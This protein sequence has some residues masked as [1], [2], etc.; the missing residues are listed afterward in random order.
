VRDQGH[1]RLGRL[2]RQRERIKIQ[3][4]E[5][6]SKLKFF[7]ALAH[8]QKKVRKNHAISKTINDR[9]KDVAVCES[10]KYD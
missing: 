4:L 9:I 6:Q 8:A 7:G 2:E 1:D 5:T 10:N 3:M